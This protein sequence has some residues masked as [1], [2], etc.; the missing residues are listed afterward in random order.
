MNCFP[1]DLFIKN[2]I[3]TKHI[4]HAETPAENLTKRRKTEIKTAIGANNLRPTTSIIEIPH[5]KTTIISDVF[6]KLLEMKMLI[7]TTI[8]LSNMLRRFTE[9]WRRIKF[10]IMCR[11]IIT[12]KEI[13]KLF[14]M[15][16]G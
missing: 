8:I 11:K 15:G 5:N 4:P 10:K 12:K 6:C 14:P 13:P 16:I 7:A 3:M 2:N 1:S 9:I